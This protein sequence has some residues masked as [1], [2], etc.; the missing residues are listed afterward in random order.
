MTE[1]KRKPLPCRV[2]KKESNNDWMYLAKITDYVI[3]GDCKQTVGRQILDEL[4]NND[5]FMDL[6]VKGFKK[7]WL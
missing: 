7:G 3:C 6:L 4:K 2:C 1:E 5:K